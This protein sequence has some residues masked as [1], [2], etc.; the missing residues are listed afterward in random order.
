MKYLSRFLGLVIVFS[1]FTC[2]PL[3]KLP[4]SPEL[5]RANDGGNGVELEIQF[6]AG[7]AHNHPTF[8]FWIEDMNENFIQTLFVTKYLATGIFGYGAK[9]NDQWKREPGI[10]ERPASLP[11][12]L[13]KRPHDKAGTLVPTPEN[14]VPDAFTG[15]TPQNN[16]ILN[17]KTDKIPQGKFRLLC[18]INQT[19]DWN[20]YWTNSK[21]PNNVDYKTSCQPSLVYAVTIDPTDKSRVYYLNPIGHG[22]FS[23]DNGKLYT[24][25][26]TLTTALQIAKKIQVRIK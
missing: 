7:E 9:S 16:F 25:I 1:G 26:S 15:A 22:H 10:A 12:W 14:P 11:Y 4:P 18:E 6:T 3:K 8:A 5:I 21:Y 19:W 23:G 2:N 20:E 13:H 17:V 24:D